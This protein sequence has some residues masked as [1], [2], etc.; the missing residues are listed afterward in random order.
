MED[1]ITT[2]T[3]PI[4]FARVG[5]S[6]SQVKREASLQQEYLHCRLPRP[7]LE[8]MHT[9]LTDT[10]SGDFGSLTALTPPPSLRQSFTRDN[11]LSPTNARETKKM[12]SSTLASRSHFLTPLS[13]SSMAMSWDWPE[14]ADSD[15]SITV[16]QKPTEQRRLAGHKHKPTAPSQ[17]KDQLGVAAGQKRKMTHDIFASA[18]VQEPAGKRVRAEP[19]VQK[20]GSIRPA[21]LRALQGF[22]RSSEPRN[23][24][25]AAAPPAGLSRLP[26]QT[27]ARPGAP[28]SSPPRPASRTFS[29]TRGDEGDAISVDFPSPRPGTLALGRATKKGP[30]SLLQEDSDADKDEAGAKAALSPP[31]P[32]IPTA[33]HKKAPLAFLLDDEINLNALFSSPRPSILA[34]ARTSKKGLQEDEMDAKPLF[35]P[36]RPSIPAAAHTSKKGP[37]SFMQEDNSSDED[38][39]D[40]KPVL[41]SPP[42][43]FKPPPVGISDAARVREKEREKEAQRLASE[44]LRKE[45]EIAR[46]KSRE[47]TAA[48][49]HGRSAETHSNHAARAIPPR[50]GGTQAY[51]N[52]LHPG[53]N[54]TV[55]KTTEKTTEKE[56]SRR[57]EVISLGSETPKIISLG[58]S[59][60]EVEEVPSRVHH[61][62]A[63]R[64]DAKRST[65]KQGKADAAAAPPV[66]SANGRQKLDGSL[67]IMNGL[68]RA[69]AFGEKPTITPA[70]YKND[71]YGRGELQG[72][73]TQ[74]QSHN[75]KPTFASR[76]LTAK[77]LGIGSTLRMQDTTRKPTV[78]VSTNADRS[79]DLGVKKSDCDSK[80]EPQRSSRSEKGAVAPQTHLGRSATNIARADPQREHQRKDSFGDSAGVPS[81]QPTHRTQPPAVHVTSQQKNDS[82]DLAIAP[83][84]DQTSRS[85]AETAE[86]NAE[87]ERQRKIRTEDPRQKWEEMQAFFR[88][89]AKKREEDDR[90]A[91]EAEQ[92]KK[93]AEA[94]RA[95][96]ALRD[97]EEV[98]RKESEEA[99]RAEK[100]RREAE[101]KRQEEA[102]LQRDAEL[103]RQQAF[104]EQLREK[105][106]AEIQRQEEG[107]RLAAEKMKAKIKEAEARLIADAER[108]AEKERQEEA[109]RQRN[110]ASRLPFVDDLNASL[111]SKDGKTACSTDPNRG[112]TVEEPSRWHPEETSIERARR[113]RVEAMNERNKRNRLSARKEMDVS[114]VPDEISSVPK[115]PMS[116]N[117]STGTQR[118]KDSTAP[119]TSKLALP[120]MT[121]WSPPENPLSTA[122][123]HTGPVSLNSAAG[124]AALSH[125]HGRPQLPT[126][127][128]SNK[129]TG[130]VSLNSAAGPN[131]LSHEHARPPVPVYSASSIF[132][133][134]RPGQSGQSKH[135]DPSLG[136]IMPE[137]VKLFFWRNEKNEWADIVEDYEEVTKIRRSEHLLRK[138]YNIVKDAVDGANVG[139][140][141]LQKASIGDADACE[142]LNLAVHGVWPVPKVAKTVATRELPASGKSVG[143]K[144]ADP[145]TGHSRPLGNISQDDIKLVRLKDS[146]YRR[147]LIPDAFEQATGKKRAEKT[148]QARYK[149]VKEALD[150]AQVVDEYTLELAEEGDLETL[151]RINGL[152]KS[153]QKSINAPPEASRLQH[154]PF[155]SG[156]RSVQIGE[157][158]GYQAPRETNTSFNSSAFGSPGGSSRTLSSG[159]EIPTPEDDSNFAGTESN[160]PT[161]GGKTMNAKAFYHI[162]DC[163]AEAREAEDEEAEEVEAPF[164]SEDYCHFAYQVQRREVTREE[165]DDDITIDTAGWVACGNP[166]T[167]MGTANARAIKQAFT[168]HDKDIN[169]AIYENSY[170]LDMRAEEGM[171]QLTLTTPEGVVQ[172]HVTRFRRTFQDHIKPSTTVSWF[173]RTCYTIKQR[174]TTQLPTPPVDEL[175]EEAAEVR[176]SVVECNV[177]DAVYTDLG[178]ANTRAI[179]HFVQLTFRS[180]TLNLTF[181]EVEKKELRT[182]FAEELKDERE[183]VLWQGFVEDGGVAREVVVEA[184]KLSGPRNI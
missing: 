148:L 67:S 3:E 24:I 107:R 138:R 8:A 27:P 34:A 104:R 15:A 98:K 181:R 72:S 161:T 155:A 109:F 123:K 21:T 41:S 96:K 145:K 167:D 112:E 30:L 59:S 11:Q 158:N 85:A 79:V 74:T 95:A 73:K 64:M 143:V 66:L 180:Q 154:R 118:L 182:Q 174:T 139:Q 81:H 136:E 38:E 147:A 76:P 90:L 111:A 179:E 52:R 18:A 173:N 150:A 29:S 9:D 142:Q 126:H 37:L 86:A 124:Q 49:K 128:S 140:Q 103:K 20:S 176:K 94:G 88:G 83:P 178:L 122:S 135:H 160:R 80:V 16:A 35:P 7:K 48:S 141:V 28:A 120:R 71:G 149:Q 119:N 99:A 5:E 44:L 113:E 116:L 97:A 92:R 159:T 166:S 165:M 61:S 131:L 13:S 60:P 146:G 75:G 42:A 23:G 130:P 175:F 46:R 101:L 68:P 129:P 43:A 62:D 91:R 115:G 47:S 1:P 184:K 56:Q 110:V 19:A 157:Q 40:A 55:L 137:D 32:S 82:E 153:S 156:L 183:G 33:V 117:S 57:T 100:T 69:R 152:V 70:A 127:S 106:E 169:N 108:K 6:H 84:V 132:P 31:R 53:F 89:A 170:S 172:I 10:N 26:S 78:D 65:E 102:V 87:V 105:K 134:T 133:A 93:E 45:R 125:D 2:P 51:E 58:S 17:T 77:N 114:D 50:M 151:A 54:R 144:R 39:I 22:P 12:S 163:L 36:P 14:D 164:T 63:K 162:L 177:G 25:Y 168:A 171:N 121:G 4:D